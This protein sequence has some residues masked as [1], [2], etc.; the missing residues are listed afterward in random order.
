M[1]LLLCVV[2]RTVLPV[3]PSYVARAWAM[4]LIPFVTFDVVVATHTHTHVQIVHLC[5][6]ELCAGFTML[7]VSRFQIGPY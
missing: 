4:G 6:Y 5:M 1:L 7:M 3:A 2:F